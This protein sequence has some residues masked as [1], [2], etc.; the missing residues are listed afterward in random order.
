MLFSCHTAYLIS[1]CN[2]TA[3]IGRQ[4]KL[5]NI[6]AAKKQLQYVRLVKLFV[7]C[8]LDSIPCQRACGLGFRSPGDFTHAAFLD[9]AWR[10]F[11][12]TAKPENFFIVFS[13][14]VPPGLRATV[15]HGCFWGI[16]GFVS[17]NIIMLLIM[18][19]VIFLKKWPYQTFFVT[20]S[21]VSSE[22]S[23]FHQVW[24]MTVEHGLHDKAVAALIWTLPGA[25]SQYKR[26]IRLFVKYLNLNIS[27]SS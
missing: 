19:I 2:F 6:F 26:I 20:K 21:A 1:K 12:P 15:C 11:P 13:S 4:T 18:M 17:S 27:Y 10:V 8:D 7:W 16:L 24:R 25:E 22:K 5:K 14:Q 3:Y 23:I 9:S